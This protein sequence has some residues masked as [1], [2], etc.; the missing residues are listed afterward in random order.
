MPSHKSKQ[1]AVLSMSTLAF[2]VCFTIWMMFGVIGI[3]IKQALRLSATEFGLLAATPILSGAIMRLP[4]GIWADR[5]GGRIVMFVLMLFCVIPVYLVSSATQYWQFLVLG[6]LLGPAGGAFSVGTAY[7]SRWF[8]RK[9][10]GFAMGMFGAGTSGAAVNIFVAPSLVDLFGWQSVP[11]FY[12][13]TLLFVAFAFW[14]LTYTDSRPAQNSRPRLRDQLSMLRDP[15]LWRYCQ[16]YSIVF[17]GFVGLSLWI[18]QY[19]AGEYGLSLTTAAMLAACFS[20]PGG[21]L[22]AV[23]GW[24]ADKL[25][26]QKV[27]WW[28]LWVGWVCLF[29]LSYPQTDIAV[30][31]ISGKFEFHVGLGLWIFSALLFALGLAWAFG[32]ASVFKHVADDF[33]QQIGLA[34]GM[35]GMVGGLGGF[36]LPILFGVLTDLT[37]VRSSAFMLL[38]GISWVSLTLMYL[39]QMR[40]TD[41]MLAS[42]ERTLPSVHAQPLPAGGE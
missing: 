31:T 23:G 3:P 22:R 28:V 30:R 1:I 34:S 17:G 25:G 26:A 36:V 2:V 40:R 38:Y 35:V 20:L 15:K 39:V 5:F 18:T 13:L 11:E 6:L 9:N 32:M 8:E 27:T 7:V 24:L 12:A 21:A 16:Y 37:Q 19:Y 4:L 41:V 14:L 33:P 10:Q 29:L 42:A